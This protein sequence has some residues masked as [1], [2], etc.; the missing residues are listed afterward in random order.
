M[1]HQFLTYDLTPNE[2]L[3][4]T[5]TIDVLNFYL[6]SNINSKKKWLKV[7]PFTYTY[8]TPGD[9]KKETSR[10]LSYE[11]IYNELKS[12][13]YLDTF[14]LNLPPMQ[15]HWLDYSLKYNLN[16]HPHPGLDFFEIDLKEIYGTANPVSTTITEPTIFVTSM[17]ATLFRHI[18]T[19]RSELVHNSSELFRLEWLIDFRNLIADTISLIDITFNRIH[20]RAEFDK[21]TTWTFNKA[22]VGERFGRRIM[23]KIR[24]IHLITGNTLPTIANEKTALNNLKELR[25]QL[26]HFDPAHFEIK[27]R[28]LPKY[29]NDII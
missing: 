23:D 2:V 11:I 28:E 20:Y 14:K 3:L 5:L 18:V 22:D 17:M 27:L 19:K 8:T 4:R 21:P 29:F 1:P 24:W 12:N 26:M 15:C 7:K 25:N 16:F 6:N 13:S 9:G 10:P